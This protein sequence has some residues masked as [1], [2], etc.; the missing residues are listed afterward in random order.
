MA[1][2]RGDSASA[3]AGDTILVLLGP[4]GAGKGTQGE[5]LSADLDI[6]KISTGDVLRAAVRD[7][8][9]LGREAKGYMDR[10]ALVPDGVILG[11]MR[12]ALAAPTAARGAILDGVVRTVPQAEGLQRLLAETGR[13][14]T[15]VVLFEISDDELVRRISGR[16]VCDR[17]QT[18]FTGLE[19]GTTCSKC[20]G[21]LVRR[22]DDEPDAVRNRLR[23]YETD[24][25]PVIAWYEAQRAPIFR[26]DA[27]GTPEVVAA[28][29]R[30]SLGR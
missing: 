12:D 13:S 14:L 3:A 21:T 17:C 5:R 27:M 9:A 29:L 7:G 4:P 8:T 24:T 18:P 11:I 30:R 1:S 25:A 19:P 16:T 6:P 2:A 22:K 26:V 20:G 15:G 10:G 28:R 23:V